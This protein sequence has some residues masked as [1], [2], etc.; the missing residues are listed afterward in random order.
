M[1]LLTALED[2]VIFARQRRNR[3]SEERHRKLPAEDMI[4]P[5]NGMAKRAK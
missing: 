4:Q 1:K 5:D 3:K 2:I